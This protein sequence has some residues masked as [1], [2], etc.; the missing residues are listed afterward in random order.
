MSEL[1]APLTPPECDLRGYE[2]MPLY[3]QRLFGSAF[4][5]LA[6]QNPRAG[7]AGQKLWWEAW[8]QC[9]A[10]SLPADDFSLSRLADF[11]ADIK[12]WR[13][14]KEIALHG[15]ILCSDGR[16]YHP[17]IC[18][19]AIEAHAKRVRDRQRK[20]KWRASRDGDGTGG[21]HPVP[22]LSRVTRRGRNCRRTRDET[23]L[24]ALTGQDRTGQYEEERD[25][26]PSQPSRGRTQGVSPVLTLNAAPEDWRHW[27]DRYEVHDGDGVN[28]P[29]VSGYFIEL[30]AFNVCE[31]A[32]INGHKRPIDW[33][34]L[35]AW[36]RDG[37]DPTE[38]IIPA[39]R[40]VAARSGYDPP[41]FLTYFDR[42][43]RE[44]AA[45]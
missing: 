19:E 43:V 13:R 14:A 1:P 41:T 9:P 16:L 11:G 29:V 5:S 44:R 17:L 30:V 22:I 33:T 37:I 39:I 8:Q 45:A 40:R 26:R 27:A 24:S 10:G 15:F 42:A 4:Y 36:L 12:A 38:V 28:R 34:P 7:L 3:G 35:I 20:A 32:G 21:Q 23:V 6:L 2:F 31:A 18:R 25:K